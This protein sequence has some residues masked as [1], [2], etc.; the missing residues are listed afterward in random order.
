MARH[1]NL[2][3]EAMQA[4][5]DGGNLLRQVGSVHCELRAASSEGADY[6]TTKRGLRF[7][8]MR[9]GG[10]GCVWG[11]RVDGTATCWPVREE[12]ARWIERYES[13]TVVG[14]K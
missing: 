7:R 13:N 6:W 10:R 4:L 5:D 11:F 2:V 12:W 3:E 1:A 8:G 14:R 9:D